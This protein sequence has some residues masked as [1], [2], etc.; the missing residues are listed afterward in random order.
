M[1]IWGKVIG[2]VAGFAIG[3]PFGA[4]LGAFAGH[5]VDRARTGAGEAG[6]TGATA[7]RQVAFTMA[8]I[9]LGAKMAKA[10]Q[11]STESCR[12]SSECSP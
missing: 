4:L 6:E 12:P 11:A 10:A 7:S 5:A 3:G 9:V 2:G 8:V 1:S